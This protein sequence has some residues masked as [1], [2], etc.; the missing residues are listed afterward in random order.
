LTPREDRTKF[1]CGGLTDIARG[2]LPDPAICGGL[3]CIPIGAR[4]GAGDACGGLTGISIG[5][6]IGSGAACGGLTGINCGDLTDRDL[7]RGEFFIAD[8]VFSRPWL[9]LRVLDLMTPN[10]SVY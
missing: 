4:K 6:L 7:L 3:T 8:L 1:A 2:V 9:V 5:V 10:D